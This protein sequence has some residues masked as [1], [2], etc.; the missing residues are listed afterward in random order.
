MGNPGET[1]GLPALGL[2][3]FD[4][5]CG[6]ELVETSPD[7]VLAAAPVVPE[8]L[9]P[10][11]V[12]HGGVYAAIAEGTASLGCNC[13]I[14][15]RGLFALGMSN[16]TSF[17]R[18]VSAG[19][20]HAEARPVHVGVTTAVWDVELRDDAERLCAVSRVTLALRAAPK[21]KGI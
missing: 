14:R 10:T 21:G 15:D 9:Q 8:L 18:P 11:G 5:H 7:R 4:R 17:M 1:D 6:V 13:A 19:K 16:A 12:V 2:S 20:I 3:S